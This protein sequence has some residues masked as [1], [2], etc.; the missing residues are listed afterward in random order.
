M[1][2]YI[3]VYALEYPASRALSF[4]WK[5]F[6]RGMPSW[7]AP[8]SWVLTLVVLAHFVWF[9]VQSGPGAPAIVDGQYVLDNHGRILKV[10]TQAEYLTLRGAAVRAFAT[11]MISFYFAPMVYWWFRRND[12][13]TD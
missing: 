13:Q 5:G 2:L 6:A 7:V 3:P 12:Q 9:I 10:L 8:C 1:A 11:L 4:S